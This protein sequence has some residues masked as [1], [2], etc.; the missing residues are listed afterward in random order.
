M[1]KLCTCLSRLPFNAL[2]PPPLFVV[3]AATTA[4]P[5][6]IDAPD[7][8]LNGE[9]GSNRRR[10]VL[11]QWQPRPV[12][13]PSSRGHLITVISIEKIYRMGP[14]SKPKPWDI[15]FSGRYCF[16]SVTGMCAFSVLR[17]K[18]GFHLNKFTMEG[19][20]V[21]I[22]KTKEIFFS[23]PSSPSW[24]SKFIAPVLNFRTWHDLPEYAWMH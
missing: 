6:F 20:C 4:V 1:S 9:G 2:S 14:F 23:S 24:N 19:R 15:C 18:R 22:R 10:G 13:W 5:P 11:L 8:A 7:C 3:F 12:R 21:I 17:Q 16:F